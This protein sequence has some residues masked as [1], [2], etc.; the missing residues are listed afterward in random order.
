MLLTSEKNSDSSRSSTS[1]RLELHFHL[2]FLKILDELCLPPQHLSISVKSESL[3]SRKENQQRDFYLCG[4]PKASRGLWV[5]LS[6]WAPAWP[7]WDPMLQSQH[8][9]KR[10]KEDSR[11]LSIQW[12]V[13]SSL[14]KPGVVVMCLYLSTSET[15]AGGSPWIPGQLD[16]HMRSCLQKVRV[17][18]L[19]RVRMLT[20]K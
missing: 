18:T 13:K 14:F 2:E 16:L 1:M 3:P 6:G 11:S 4:V 8:R 20:L 15:K 9:R 5:A 12:L 7:A 10:K 17:H 19:A